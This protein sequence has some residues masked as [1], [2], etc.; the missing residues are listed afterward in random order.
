MAYTVEKLLEIARNEIGYIEKET[1]SQLDSKT[2]NAG[3]NNYTKYARDLAAAGY[4]QASKQGFAWCDMFHDWIHYIAAGKNADEAQRVICQSGPY[5]AGCE[6]SAKYYKDA[7]RYY[8]SNPQPGDQ[9]FFGNFAH[10]GVVEKVEGGI[11]T[12]IEGNTTNQVARRTY[13]ISDSYI[14][15]YG[16]PRYDASAPINPSPA[17]SAPTTYKVGDIVDFTG[18]RHYVSA[19]ATTGPACRPGKAKITATYNG[20]HPYHLIAVSGGGSDVYGWVDACDIGNGAQSSWT[21]TVGDI[22]N[23]TGN[24]HYVSA[25]AAT[26]PTCRPGKAKITSIYQV[27]NSKHPYHLVNISGGGSDV[28]GWVDAGTFTKA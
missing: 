13:S 2:A 23:F 27:N 21:P 8:T 6:W 20:K 19:N 14:D 22:V 24:K 1:N 25:N 18:N 28:Y 9:I 15:G 5:G 26:G 11:V 3:D 7:G 10:T 17:P 16:R 12:T 4:Y